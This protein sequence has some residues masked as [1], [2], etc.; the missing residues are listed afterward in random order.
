[1][2]LTREDALRL[3]ASDGLAHFRSQFFISDPELCY[4][5]GNSLGRLPKRTIDSVNHFLTHEWGEKIVDGWADWIDEAARSGDL[6][7]ESALGA[8]SGQVLACDTTSVNFY[9]LCAAAF[10]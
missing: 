6:I 3:D 8:A 1:M 5:D 2:A 10:R 9:Q 4:L 7:G